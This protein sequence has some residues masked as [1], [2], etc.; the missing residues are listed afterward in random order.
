VLY[1]YPYSN[2]H[3]GA[4]EQDLASGLKYLVENN[5]IRVFSIAVDLSN[6]KLLFDFSRIIGPSKIKF[7]SIVLYWLH[8]ITSPDFT[9]RQSLTL[10]NFNQIKQLCQDL[11]IDILYTNTTSTFIYGIQKNRKH[12]HR[13]VCFEPIYTLKTVKNPIKKIIHSL[14]KIFTILKEL[15]CDVIFTIS[16]RDSKYYRILSLLFLSKVNI[17]VLPLRQF[18]Y[19]KKFSPKKLT[20]QFIN[21]GFMGSTYNVLHN[22]RSLKYLLNL[23]SKRYLHEN[24]FIFNIYGKKIPKCIISKYASKN[25]VFHEWVENIESIYERNEVFLVPNFLNSGM[26]SKVFEPLVAGRILLCDPK[27]LSNYDFQSY[28]HFLPS[29]NSIEFK[30]NLLWVKE[31]RVAAEK[32][33]H[34]AQDRALELIGFK[35]ITRT[36]DKV[37]LV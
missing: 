21:I 28:R 7:K 22:E 24:D 5:N 8:Y 10:N 36:I 23:M 18:L 17:Q 32:I 2:G 30:K 15:Q 29:R 26:Q 13:S 16:P 9:L 4:E 25:I 35:K 27:V 34:Q 31:N 14:L 20:N 19:F 12:I 3:K 11:Q 6:K 1:I 37:L 33:S